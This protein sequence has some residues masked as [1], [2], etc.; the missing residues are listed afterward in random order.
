M[1]NWSIQDDYHSSGAIEA[2]EHDGV[3]VLV[4][5][6]GRYPTAISDT[7]LSTKETS[8][9]LIAVAGGHSSLHGEFYSWVTVT[10][11]GGWESNGYRKVLSVYKEN[12]YDEAQYTSSPEHW[13]A[14]G[15]QH[16]TEA[17]NML[18]GM[19]DVYQNSKNIVERGTPYRH[20]LTREEYETACR[21]CGVEPCTDNECDSYGVRYGDFRYPEY[22]PEHV[23]AMSLAYNRLRQIDKDKAEREAQARQSADTGVRREPMAKTGQLW[24][25]CEQCG[26]EPV[27]MPLLLCDKCW[28]MAG[29][30]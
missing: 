10:A 7:G 17:I 18:R 16:L 1:A 11:M 6:G 29:G 4:A 8:H 26:R 13:I 27:Y 21:E 15:K 9:I 14:K 5:H 24:E 30:E 19:D 2:Y 25:P 22:S 28:P 20:P 12:T 23:L 3:P